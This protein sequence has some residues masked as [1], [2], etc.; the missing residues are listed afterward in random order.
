MALLI[1]AVVFVAYS[2]QFVVHCGVNDL[3]ENNKEV[4]DRLI[5]AQTVRNKIDSI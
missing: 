3:I 2:T 5:F 1:F 4:D